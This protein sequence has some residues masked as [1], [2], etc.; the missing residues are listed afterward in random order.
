MTQ[1]L[2]RILHSY[3][4][5][6][7]TSEAVVGSVLR[8]EGLQSRSHGS[9]NNLHWCVVLIHC[10]SEAHRPLG[11]QGTVF[12]ESGICLASPVSQWRICRQVRRRKPTEY[13]YLGDN[14]WETL[15]AIQRVWLLSVYYR[16]YERFSLQTAVT[17]SE[18]WMLTGMIIQSSS[19]CWIP[20]LQVHLWVSTR[21]LGNYRFCFSK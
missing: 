21:G 16:L 14:Q 1:T 5:V 7:P 13:Q 6:A 17:H 11:Q 15:H 18:N 10:G 3:S 8:F 2:F 9:C 20:A 19:C 4:K 12:S